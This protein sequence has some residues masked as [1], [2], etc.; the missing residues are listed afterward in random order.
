MNDSDNKILQIRVKWTKYGKYFHRTNTRKSNKLEA[1]SLLWCSHGGGNYG[2]RGSGES[3]KSVTINDIRHRI[4]ARMAIGA[5][6]KDKCA[7]ALI[8][9]VTPDKRGIRIYGGDLMIVWHIV[10]EFQASHPDKP[11]AY[12]HMNHSRKL[13]RLVSQILSK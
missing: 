4:I 11:H 10:D 6:L 9:N 7:G 1:K 12:S 8:P 5:E 3:C 13:L 2:G